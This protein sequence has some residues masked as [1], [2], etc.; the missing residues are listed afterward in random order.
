MGAEQSGEAIP[1][2]QGI[3]IPATSRPVQPTNQGSRD[4]A[5]DEESRIGKEVR[6]G[7]IENNGVQ[8]NMK[9]LLRGERGS[10]K[11]SLWQRLQGKSFPKSYLPTG[12]IQTAT[13]NWSI[14]NN[15]NR[16]IKVEVWDVVDNGFL[17]SDGDSNS[18][19]KD[20]T[21]NTPSSS[22]TVVEGNHRF[23]ALDAS[24]IGDLH[25]NTQAV[26]YLL[27]PFSPSSLDYVKSSIKKVPK[28]MDVLFILN[29]R[30]RLADVG[31]A[32]RGEYAPLEGKISESGDMGSLPMPPMTS[33]VNAPVMSQEASSSSEDRSE[34]EG[35]SEK[36][37]EQEKRKVKEKGKWREEDKAKAKAK[38][39]ARICKNM[40]EYV[41]V[42]TQTHQVCSSLTSDQQSLSLKTVNEFAASLREEGWQS[43]TAIE[44]SSQNCYG[45]K[46]MYKFMYLPFLQ[47]SLSLRL[48]GLF[49]YIGGVLCNVQW[50]IRQLQCSSNI[51]YDITSIAY[52]HYTDIY[53]L[54]NI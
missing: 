54:F 24:C 51:N 40:Q 38:A 52:N 44:I 22:S 21:K 50:C 10:G 11:T 18:E 3:F 31:P 9:M 37:K 35:K 26:V 47:V 13:I 49:L 29:F 33:T 16:G 34:N 41:E 36:E 43:I 53:P 45:L 46:E 15:D 25:K 8:Y 5:P 20:N 2:E 42:C 28:C 6:Q 7:I 48:K 14:S 19:K 12:E 39:K 32:D 1:P 17:L 30:D 4:V 23:M 27:N